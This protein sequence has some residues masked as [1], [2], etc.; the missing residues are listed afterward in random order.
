[1]SEL[2]PGPWTIGWMDN[3]PTTEVPDRIISAEGHMLIEFEQVW[4]SATD[5]RAMAAA[6]Q[7]LEALEAAADSGYDYLWSE[8]TQVMVR[9]AIAQA[10]GDNAA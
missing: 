7:L 5:I 8:E 4:A 6:P 1:M 2:S 10:R 9:D 3:D